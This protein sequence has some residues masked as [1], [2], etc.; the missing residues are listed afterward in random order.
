[1]KKVWGPRAITPVIPSVQADG[2]TYLT[3][4]PQKFK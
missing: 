2:L 1:L 4:T 3:T